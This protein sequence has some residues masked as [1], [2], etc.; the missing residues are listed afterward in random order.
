MVSCGE[1]RF[2]NLETHCTVADNGNIIEENKRREKKN[3]ATVNDHSEQ[4]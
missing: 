3:W 1:R 2:Q 4:Q